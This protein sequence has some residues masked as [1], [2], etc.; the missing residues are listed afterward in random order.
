MVVGERDMLGSQLVR[1]NDEVALLHQKIRLQQAALQQVLSR[2]PPPLPTH[3]FTSC[4]PSKLSPPLPEAR[5]FPHLL[6]QP[7]I[8][9]L[10]SFQ[11]LCRP[12]NLFSFL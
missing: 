11:S 7:T 2:A 5:S 1:Q 9:H 3:P 4:S 6:F 12:S 8:H 10:I